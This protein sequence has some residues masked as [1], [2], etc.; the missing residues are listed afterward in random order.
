MVDGPYET[1]PD[2]RLYEPGIRD[3]LRAALPVDQLLGYEALL[4]LRRAAFKL[5][6][7]TQALR[8]VAAQDDPGMR[9]LIRLHGEPTGV[10]VDDLVA[11]RGE[12]VLGV[13]DELDRER[14]IVRSGASVRLSHLGTERI[15]GALRRLA[16]RVATLVEGVPAEHLAVLRDVSLRLIL[17]HQGR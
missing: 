7:H 3:S 1:D 12:E 4:G 17:N 14:M 9:V 5:D 13:L 16:D 10:A 8:N 11:D 6:K 15:N 2:G